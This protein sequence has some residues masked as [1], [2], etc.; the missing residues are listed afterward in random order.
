MPR[1]KKLTATTDAAEKIKLRDE[2]KK[3]DD[4]SDAALK[5]VTDNAE[6]AI[7][8][9]VAESTRS[10]E[11]YV[12]LAVRM[13]TFI[14][15]LAILACVAGAGLGF[16]VAQR[17][18][19]S[20]SHIADDLATGAGQ[21]AAAASQVS[22]ASQSLAQ[23]ASES[24]ASLEESSASLEEIASMTRQN[25]TNAEK[26]KDL[27]GQTRQAGDTG[28]REM[29]AMSAAMTEIKKSSDSIAKIIKTI[30]EIAF[31][32]NILA[33]NAAVEAARAGEAGMGFAVVADEVRNLAQRCAQAAK[34]TAAQIEDSVRKSQHGVE[35][36]ARVGKSLDEIVIKARQVDELAAGVASASRE[37]NQG[38][39]QVNTAVSQMDKVTQSN[40]ANAEESAAAAEE[41]NSQAVAM[42]SAVAELL[43][44]VGSQIA[45]AP[46]ATR[47]WRAPKPPAAAPK[48]VELRR[49]HHGNGRGK[50]VIKLAGASLP[51]DLPLAGDFK[52]F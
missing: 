27:A 28:A 37:Q 2:L 12:N 20:I 48:N 11:A 13:R 52:D 15:G 34:E 4:Q 31:Q 8:S 18:S 33:L 51:G 49:H 45:S 6:R 25:T 50:K 24:A 39:T 40:A 19:N 17:I 43:Q 38:V 32:T 16:W 3:F 10:K 22:V 1:V 9:L 44:L 23:G 47:T 14:I 41:L 26:A 35:I 29:Q 5:T 30:D 7:A 42:Q 36:C 21:T 46:T